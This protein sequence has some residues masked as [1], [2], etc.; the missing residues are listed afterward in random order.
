MK[1]MIHLEVKLSQDEVLL[2]LQK[3]LNELIGERLP[4][5]YSVKMEYDQDNEEFSL[6]F[7]ED[8]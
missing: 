3:H 4:N 2:A 1:T 7:E 8:K 6:I 5:R